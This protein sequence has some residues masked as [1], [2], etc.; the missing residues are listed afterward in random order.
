MQQRFEAKIMQLW[1]KLAE[2]MKDGPLQNDKD[3]KWE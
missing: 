2:V 1:I 3:R